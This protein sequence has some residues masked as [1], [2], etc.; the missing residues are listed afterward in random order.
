MK[1]WMDKLKYSFE[2]LTVCY[3]GG[4]SS[5]EAMSRGVQVVNELLKTDNNKIAIVTHGAILTLILKHFNNNIGFHEWK[6][7]LYPDIYLIKF[8]EKEE[9]EILRLFI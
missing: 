1:D 2:D 5:N 4:E 7:L 9:V 3:E 6:N 8:K